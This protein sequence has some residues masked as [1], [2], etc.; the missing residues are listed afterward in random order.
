ML[1][2]S[3]AQTQR[4]L[5]FLF[6]RHFFPG[7]Q[8]T[9]SHVS[10]SWK[11]AGIQTRVGWW[12]QMPWAVMP[13]GP[14]AVSWKT[15]RDGGS[16]L[17][18]CIQIFSKTTLV[19]GFHYHTQLRSLRTDLCRPCFAYSAGFHLAHSTRGKHGETEQNSASPSQ[20]VGKLRARRPLLRACRL[21]KRR[22]TFTGDAVGGASV[23]NHPLEESIVVHILLGPRG[24][25]TA[26]AAAL[27][28][29]QFCLIQDLAA[30]ILGLAEPAI[31]SCEETGIR[32]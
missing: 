16:G 2:Q 3:G 27:L 25:Q 12:S 10:R 30:A 21:G 32:R 1:E 23:E 8:S 17:M 26:G 7:P 15:A 5:F 6:I 28:F 31:P 22:P 18:S 24:T 19:G 11:E 13:G 4:G 9:F 20:T 29:A 14:Q